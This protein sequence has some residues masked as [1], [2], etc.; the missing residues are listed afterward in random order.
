MTKIDYPR[1]L[2]DIPLWRRRR[3]TEDILWF[4]KYT[5]CERLDHIDREWKE[6]QDFVRQFGLRE[7]GTR[8]GSRTAGRDSQV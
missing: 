3:I 8:K 6:I 7:Y 4:S 1:A 5:P 2:R